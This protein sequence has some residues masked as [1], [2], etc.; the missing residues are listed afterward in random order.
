[1]RWEAKKFLSDLEKFR[2][3][4]KYGGFDIELLEK[5]CLFGT[6]VI[7]L[8][9]FTVSRLYFF[10]SEET[11]YS[12]LL[13]VSLAGIFSPF[14][15]FL[16]F[17]LGAHFGKAMA[18]KISMKKEGLLPEGITPERAELIES[19][20][21]ILESPEMK[22]RVLASFMERPKNTGTVKRHIKERNLKRLR[23]AGNDEEKYEIICDIYRLPCLLEMSKKE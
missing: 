13:S 9:I 16:T 2:K 21:E 20:L 14:I 23:K 4:D 15:G 22:D 17:L 1:M 7:F 8:A 5:E 18:E 19:V 12:M 11:G 6:A 3:L 10:S